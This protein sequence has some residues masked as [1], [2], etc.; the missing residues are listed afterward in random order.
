[1]YSL[2]HK[3]DTRFTHFI[4]AWPAW[5]RPCMLVSSIIG[6][7]V[8]TLSVGVVIAF[9]G[10]LFSNT[11]LFYAGTFAL[12]ALGVG[13]VLKLALRRKRPLTDYVLAMRIKSFSFPSG[14]S[15][16]SVVSFGLFAFLIVPS[17]P[18]ALGLGVSVIIALLCFS[19]GISRVYLGAHYPSDV[20]AG[21]MLGLL[22][23]IV[24]IG[25]LQPR[26]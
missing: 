26:L 21:W 9:F 25:S 22:A 1:M 17:L 10:V 7:P 11:S 16:G 8:V 6:L 14:H 3:F 20:V 4:Q 5:V 12:A 18:A 13:S 24:I 15:L 23:L 2:L 19:I